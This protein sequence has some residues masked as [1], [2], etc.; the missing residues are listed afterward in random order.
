MAHE[1]NQKPKIP[2]KPIQPKKK[3]KKKCEPSISNSLTR[4]FGSKGEALAAN[5]RVEQRGLADIRAAYKRKLR[6]AIGGAILG[7]DTAFDK[8]GLRNLS[9]PRVL[10]QHNIRALQDSRTQT[11]SR[12]TGRNVGFRGDKELLK[13]NLDVGLFLRDSEI[14]RWVGDG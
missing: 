8:I 9:V 14:L 4:F 10:S 1:T 12:T 3:K 13:G 6:E 5:K 11:R 7:P 2:T